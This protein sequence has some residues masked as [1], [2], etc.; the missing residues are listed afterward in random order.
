MVQFMEAM[1]VT[2]RMM[3]TLTLTKGDTVVVC[4]MGT[5]GQEWTLNGGP[6]GF[7]CPHAIEVVNGTL[8]VPVH[9]CQAFGFTFNTTLA[10]DGIAELTTAS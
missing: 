4:T 3:G 8:M 7:Q 2:A 5:N 10:R 9:L 6:L 1:G